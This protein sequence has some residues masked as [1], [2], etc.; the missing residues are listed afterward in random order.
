MMLVFKLVFISCRKTPVE[1]M[2]AINMLPRQ[3]TNT[4]E[5]TALRKSEYANLGQ[6][7]AASKTLNF[8]SESPIATIWVFISENRLYV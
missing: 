2:Y 1:T 8:S 6:T 3:H 4:Y 5:L 7:Y